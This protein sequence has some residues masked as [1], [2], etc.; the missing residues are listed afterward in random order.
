LHSCIIQCV[1][2]NNNNI[3]F[4]FYFF[5]KKEFYADVADS[6]DLIHVA[7]TKGCIWFFFFFFIRLA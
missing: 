5:Y 3:K 7:R 1:N 6:L 2:N 4:I